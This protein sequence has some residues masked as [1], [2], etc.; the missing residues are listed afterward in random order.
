MMGLYVIRF[1]RYNSKGIENEPYVSINY[2]APVGNP[3][4]FASAGDPSALGGDQGGRLKEGMREGIDWDHT[5][6]STRGEG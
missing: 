5:N 1:V 6:A 2:D 4:N 3:I